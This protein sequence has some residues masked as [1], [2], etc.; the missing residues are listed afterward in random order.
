[1][2]DADLPNVFR[3]LNVRR[4]II[5]L[6]RPGE[7]KPGRIVINPTNAEVA[8]FESLPVVRPVPGP[9]VDLHDAVHGCLVDE[10]TREEVCGAIALDTGAP[11]IVVL[12]GEA[13]GKSWG[14]GTLAMFELPGGDGR[15][16]VREEFTIGR[17]ADASRLT[18]LPQDPG[19]IPV[20]LSGM[21]IYFAYS[22]LYDPNHGTVGFKARVPIPGGPYPLTGAR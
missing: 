16:L 2:A 7:V 21:T 15:A 19:T 5:D 18:F 20:I 6:P 3:S 12:S 9:L 4:W 13:R 10:V 22:V 8:G 11:G 14:T 1:M 17:R